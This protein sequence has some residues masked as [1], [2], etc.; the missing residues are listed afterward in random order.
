[1]TFEVRERYAG[2]TDDQVTVDMQTV[3]SDPEGP[4]PAAVYGVGSRLLISGEPR[5]GGTPLDAPIAWGC[6]FSR[7]YDEKTA[8]TWRET[9]DN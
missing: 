4:E 7:Y 3:M 2:G 9:F 5:W 6:G 1:M 8:A